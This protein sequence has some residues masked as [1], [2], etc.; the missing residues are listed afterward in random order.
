ML[1]TSQLGCLEVNSLLNRIEVL[2]ESFFSVFS[3]IELY[4]H[5][6]SETRNLIVMPDIS[7]LFL[8]LI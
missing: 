6:L 7:T 1:L 3:P 4:R 2:P 8:C 5:L